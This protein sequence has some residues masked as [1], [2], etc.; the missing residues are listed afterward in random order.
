M[1]E[2]WK[3]ANQGNLSKGQVRKY[4]Q[5]SVCNEYFLVVLDEDGNIVRTAKSTKEA[6]KE[7]VNTVTGHDYKVKINW[8]ELKDEEGN[9]IGYDRNATKTATLECTREGCFEANS[10]WNNSGNYYKEVNLK[11]YFGGNLDLKLEGKCTDANGATANYIATV[12]LL[13]NGET[14]TE[15]K[16]VKVN[17]HLNNDYSVTSVDV[18]G[19]QVHKHA[20]VCMY[21]GQVTGEYVNCTPT[22]FTADDITAEGHKGACV[23]G[24]HFTETTE[25]TLVG[26]GRAGDINVNGYVH[27][28]NIMKCSVCGYETIE[29][30]HKMESTDNGHYCTVCGTADKKEPHTYTEWTKKANGQYTSNCSVCGKDK[31]DSW[32]NIC[33]SV[34]EWANNGAGYVT[35]TYES[36]AT[37][38]FNGASDKVVP[39]GL[40]LVFKSGSTCKFSQ[41]VTVEGVIVVE[42]GANYQTN[43]HTVSV[44]RDVKG[45]RI[46]GVG[47]VPEQ[48]NTQESFEEA[49]EEAQEVI[50]NCNVE[51]ADELKNL[52]EEKTVKINTGSTMKVTGALAADNLKIEGEGTVKLENKKSEEDNGTN[53]TNAFK[54]GAKNVELASDAKLQAESETNMSGNLTI[55]EGVTF[56]TEA[57]AHIT[58]NGNESSSLTLNGTWKVEG[59]IRDLDRCTFGEKSVIELASSSEENNGKSLVICAKADVPNVK[60]DENAKLENDKKL[61][62]DANVKL[63]LNNKKVS[64]ENQER[65]AEVATNGILTISNGTIEAKQGSTPDTATL[66]TEGTLTLDKVTVDTK[67]YGVFVGTNGN[68]TIN[69]GTFTSSERPCIGTNNSTTK[70]SDIT[71]TNATLTTNKEEEPAVFLPAKGEATFENCTIK[72]GTAIEAVGLTKLNLKGTTKLIATRNSYTA[73]ALPSGE[74]ASG[75]ALLIVVRNNYSNG[76]TMNVEIDSGVTFEHTAQGTASA[77]EVFQD[78]SHKGGLNKINITHKTENLE[79]HDGTD[80]SC[81]VTVG[82]G[83]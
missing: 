54:A 51:V 62:V 45:A 57:G 27:H 36:D 11:P 42:S 17:G 39:E 73:P 5:C 8:V 4:G 31:T 75:S 76:E 16:T 72:G 64:K 68:L 34:P 40:K 6:A 7:P 18:D 9:V 29:E 35:V 58:D 60:L 83:L 69:G 65:I 47:N 22:V 24:Y 77:V 20:P 14:F 26:S 66:K 80:S 59:E 30:N 82:K 50:V 2:G 53:L 10:V 74:E 81:T 52:D 43:S 46:E 23:C 32:K 38:N 49:L 1:E 71:V 33:E 15:T 63:D 13:D 70:N 28:G 67:G 37:C 61:E 79:Y 12:E 25:H 44:N 41:D 21:C 19:K 3:K 78:N 55:D 48:V 56:T